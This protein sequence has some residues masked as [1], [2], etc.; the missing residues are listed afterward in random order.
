M[1]K[2]NYDSQINNASAITF[3]MITEG[4]DWVKSVKNYV[5]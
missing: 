1:Y 2:R 5:V 3:S 4:T